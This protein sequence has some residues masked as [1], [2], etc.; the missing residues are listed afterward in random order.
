MKLIEKYFVTGVK[1]FS[2]ILS[3]IIFNYILVAHLL[4]L[5]KPTEGYIDQNL[6]DISYLRFILFL[7]F[8]LGSIAWII[9]FSEKKI[10][11]EQPY[12]KSKTENIF[13]L[14]TAFFLAVFYIEPFSF[15]H[16]IQYPFF[17]LLVFFFYMFIPQLI[18]LYQ[19]FNYHEAWKFFSKKPDFRVSIPKVSMPKVGEELK[20]K[21]ISYVGI[22]VF[23][24]LASIISFYS[25]LFISNL[26][27][28][29][30]QGRIYRAN[31]VRK[32]FHIAR[33]I[34][35]KALNTQQVTVEGYN[36]GWPTPLG[37]NSYRVLTND[38]PVRL[39]DEWTNERIKFIVSLDQPV[40]KKELWIERP[41][42]NPQN[43]QVIKSN[44]VSFDVLSRFVLYPQANDS[45]L[46]RL[47]KRV[48]R[49]LFFNLPFLDNV[50]V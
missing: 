35:Q 8:F 24:I 9:T 49:I 42:D 18:Q 31:Q 28:D 32:Q 10:K 40:G 44:T 19:S 36:F 12:S 41:T 33:A 30:M 11:I 27:R 50:I 43:S 17:I 14:V 47:V 22:F 4:R 6:F 37:N 38:G 16:I 34:P 21:T 13:C 26:I 2:Q 48:K 1:Y 15:L 46:T 39:V 25:F 20:R 23:L 7:A 5:I 3:F 45:L 29:Y